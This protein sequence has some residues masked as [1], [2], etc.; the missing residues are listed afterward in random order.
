[1]LGK[2]KNSTIKG[3]ATLL[4]VPEIEQKRIRDRSWWSD[5]EA[6]EKC[7]EWWLS[8]GS[9][10]TWKE[11]INKLDYSGEVYAANRVRDWLEKASGKNTF[12]RIIIT[13]LLCY[14][15]FHMDYQTCNG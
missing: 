1:M 12:S 11:I 10:V 2:S 15:S 4:G 7:I 9:R 6:R 3:F 5:A 8:H 13:L 14:I